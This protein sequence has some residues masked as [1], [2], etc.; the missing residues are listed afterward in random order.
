MEKAGNVKEKNSK[1]VSPVLP[2]EMPKINK[3]KFAQV[4]QPPPP[5]HIIRDNWHAPKTPRI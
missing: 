1:R 4:S 2:S 3:V 5:K